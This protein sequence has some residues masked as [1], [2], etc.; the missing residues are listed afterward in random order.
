MSMIINNTKIK[1]EMDHEGSVSKAFQKMSNIIEEND[2]TRS[3]EWITDTCHDQQAPFQYN[4]ETRIALTSSQHLISDFSKGFLTVHFTAGFKLQG[5]TASNFTDTNHLIKLFVGWKSSNQAVRQMQIWVNGHSIGYNQQEMIREGFAY[6]SC[7]SKQE[8]ATKRFIHSL[9][10]NVSKYAKSICGVY[11]NV[12][13]LKS[14]D[15]LEASW[16]ANIPFDNFLVLQAFD[17]FPNFAI[18]NVELRLYFDP[19]GLVWCPVDP[20]VVYDSKVLI[21]G[22]NIG[23]SLPQNINFKRGFT[24]IGNAAMC[25]SSFSLDTTAAQTALLS[26]SNYST[27]TQAEKDAY[28]INYLATNNVKFS[29]SS[30]ELTLYCQTM[31]ITEFSSHMAGF[32]VCEQ[33]LKE[34]S[35]ILSEG[36]IIPSQ[37]LMYD[38]FPDAPNARGIQTNLRATFSN[39]TSLSIAFPKHPNDLTVFENPVYQNL[40]LRINNKN[41]PD[42]TLSTVGAEFLQMQLIASDLD[43]SIECTQEFEDS[44]TQDRNA[45]DGTRYT[46]MLSDCS[47]FLWNLQLERNGGGYFFDGFESHG[48]NISVELVGG[49][50]Y[51]GA[52][53]TYYNV[54]AAGTIHPPAPQCFSCKDT[55]IILMP[56]DMKFKI[57]GE[58][59]IISTQRDSRQLPPT[60]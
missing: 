50:V 23:A 46:N 59:D 10:E 17:L 47:S 27:M 57:N 4:Q 14:G 53:D 43:G 6:S 33:S 54:D 41:Y 48:Q 7:M 19:A 39:V 25:P 13:D 35:Q 38:G 5:I 18:P 8:K 2:G 12:D 37:I 51:S 55:Y 22:D 9:Y 58:P 34:I 42:K 36:I 21:E 3:F 60:H 52:N 20:Y 49:P 31:R 30:T 16:D 26:E 40:Q 1:G 32:G 11:L 24:Q 29:V 15:L 45:P 28:I 56:G 44:F